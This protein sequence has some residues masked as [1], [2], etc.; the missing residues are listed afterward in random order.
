MNDTNHMRSIYNKFKNAG[1][2]LSYI[3]SLLPEWWDERLADTPSG[4]QYASLHLARMFSI[5]PES[6]KDESEGICFNFGGNHK[7]KHRNNVADD[8]LD[9]ATAIAYTAARIV[10]SNFKKPYDPQIVLD[11]EL[12]RKDTMESNPW[13]SLG[14]LVEYC[15]SV[16]IPVIYIKNFPRGAKKMAGLALMSCGRPVIILTQPQKYGYMLFDLAHELGHIAK[17]HL[18]AENGQCHV[19]EKIES[20]S[21]S[22]IEKEANEFAFQVLSG[23]KSLRIV[24]TGSFLKAH[25]LAN[26]ARKFGSERGVDPTHIALN[27]GFVMGHWG[28]A[29][30][31]VKAICGGHPTDQDFIKDMMKK[32][33][34]LESINEDDLNILENLIGE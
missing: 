2:N 23:Q 28:V 21:T 13:V 5:L 25:Q 8:D 18:N 27:Y 9:I 17:G 30:N 3:R 4:R 26:A 15:H 16:G 14:G 19:D 11:P 12:I 32:G 6:L 33:I 29:V 24:P 22:D 31:A 7:F 1:F 34:D 20:A 10:A